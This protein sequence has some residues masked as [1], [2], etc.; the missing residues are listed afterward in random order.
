MKKTILF[1]GIIML[2]FTATKAQTSTS[3]VD[4]LGSWDLVM[5]GLPQ[6]DVNCQ[7]H[8]NEKDG[9]LS[10]FLKFDDTDAGKVIIVNPEIK[11]SVLVFNATLQGYDVDFN[12]VQNA[13]K[14]LNGSLYN[15]MFTA[16]GQ[17]SK[18]TDPAKSN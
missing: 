15:G 5:L 13:D 12:L 10:G 18:A 17:R 8:L 1:F 14:R 7:L 16:V 2:A 6:G 4:F 9:K 11:D 3:K